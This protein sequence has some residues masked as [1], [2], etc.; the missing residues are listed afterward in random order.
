M[1]TLWFASEFWQLHALIETTVRSWP[2]AAATGFAVSCACLA[3]SL[4]VLV[5]LGLRAGWSLAAVGPVR[6]TF[7]TIL[8]LSVSLP[9]YPIV[10]GLTL[11]AA[12]VAF[13]FV[14]L[15]V[16]ALAPLFLTFGFWTLACSGVSD[17]VDEQQQMRQRNV[18]VQDISCTQLAFGL[19]MGAGSFVTFGTSCILLTV[20]KSPVVFVACVGHGA[21]HSFK[22]LKKTG[23]W[24]PLATI[25]WL[26][27]FACYLLLILL[28][29]ML[30]AVSKP[31]LAAV[32][33]AYVATGWLRAMGGRVRGRRSEGRCC[34]AFVQSVKAGYQVLWASDLVTNACILWRLDLLEQTGREFW[35]I[36]V[37]TREELS[38]ECR[39][40]ACLPPVVVGLFTEDSWDWDGLDQALASALDVSVD[41]LHAAWDSLER[42]MRTIGRAE[43]DAG[44]LTREYIEGVPPE[45]VI[46]LPARV[47]LQTVERTKHS[48]EPR[49]ELANGLCFTEWNRPR[50]DFADRMWHELTTAQAALR[51]LPSGGPCQASLRA[52]LLAGGADPTELPPRLAEELAAF[53]QLSSAEL[54]RCQAVQ[55][56]LIAV[57]IECSRQQAFKD[58]L[59]TV[60][61]SLLLVEAVEAASP[62]EDGASSSSSDSDSDASL[63]SVGA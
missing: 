62:G 5:L 19:L 26:M 1:D 54:A 55:R 17:F 43:L 44:C 27:L 14:T 51:E 57:A 6:K 47:L 29:I 2:N 40:V 58:R 38:I 53:D 32:W 31:V 12:W 30:S 61:E 52:V 16:G 37:G 36:A 33:P 4:P 63:L 15:T 8:L 3:A 18:R 41:A 23:W 25:A 46:G 50:S 42:Q 34:K 28:G 59:G 13:A 20:L 10:G 56:P 24:L 39:V 9:L 21:Y 45:L 7:S 48:E 49:L 22:V 35:E 11:A 60:V